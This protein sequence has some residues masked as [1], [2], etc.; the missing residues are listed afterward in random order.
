MQDDRRC[1]VQFIHPGGEHWPDQDGVKN[2]NFGSH[3]R[4]FLVSPGQ[5][6]DA[7]QMR[8]GEIVFWGEWEPESRVVER[9]QQRLPDGPQFLYEPFFIE[10][11]RYDT[12]RQNTDPFVF[13]DQFHYTWCLQ[14]TKRGETQLRHLAR[15]SVILFGSCLQKSRFVIDTVLVVAD[16]IDHS[17]RDY[18]DKLDGAVSSIYERVTITTGYGQLGESSLVHR[19]YFGATYGRALDAMFSF[20]PCQP[21]AEAP[22]G[23]A[24]PAIF[25][26][27]LITPQLTQGKKIARL[28]TGQEAR[29]LWGEVCR[30]VREQGL[31]LGV[32]AELPPRRQQRA[33]RDPSEGTDTAE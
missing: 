27:G 12:G 9:Y 7:G 6:V 22:N 30:Q 17:A 20:F 16:Y 21:R 5:Y 29:D 33:L 23:F 24:R 1:F 19:L 26:P 14:N 3:R 2:W 25:I 10:P 13:G 31:A 15:G 11:D 18:R 32:R 28:S 8:D 4:K